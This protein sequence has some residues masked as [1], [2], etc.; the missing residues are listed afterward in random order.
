MMSSNPTPKPSP[1]IEELSHSISNRPNRRPSETSGED[2]DSGS[3]PDEAMLDK[4]KMKKKKVEKPMVNRPI[5]PPKAAPVKIVNT[6][7]LTMPPK[8]QKK[9]PDTLPETH[10]QV[11]NKLNEYQNRLPRLFK[12]DEKDSWNNGVNRLKE[13]QARSLLATIKTRVISERK[14]IVINAMYNKFCDL[15]EDGMVNLL[16]MGDMVGFSSFAK[17][18]KVLFEDDLAEIACE[19]SDNWIP[20]AK[21]RLLVGIVSLLDDFKRKKAD[22]ALSLTSQNKI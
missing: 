21:T 4:L 13:D 1:S 19:M 15:S 8:P 18:S 9:T 11:V 14:T 6:K 20:G 22:E 5:T 3:D 2:S 10:Q 17:D 7:S 12:P 16:A